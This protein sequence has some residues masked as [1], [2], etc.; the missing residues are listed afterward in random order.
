MTI[1]AGSDILAA[2]LLHIRKLSCVADQDLTIGQPV[3]ISNYVTGLKV[4]KAIK[5]T[6]SATTSFT[7]NSSCE[8]QGTAFA[9]GGDKFIFLTSDTAADT[10]YATVGSIATGTKS[11]SLGTSVAVTTD[12]TTPGYTGCK[13]DTDKFIVFYLEDASTTIVKYRV[14]TVSGTTITFGAAATYFTGGTAITAT[15][16]CCDQL[17]TDKAVAFF[18][19]S[20]VTDS[21]IVA[22]TVSSTTATA[23][24]PKA[25]G[26]TIDNVVDYSMIKKTSTDKFILALDSGSA[27]SNYCQIGTLSGTTITLGTETVFSSNDSFGNNTYSMKIVVPSSDVVVIKHNNTSNISETIVGTISGTTPTFGTPVAGN[28]YDISLYSDT[29]SS[30]LLGNA[31][32]GYVTKYTFSGTT[33]TQVGKC[34]YLVSNNSISNIIS[35][36]NGYF[37]GLTTTGTTIHVYIQGASNNFIGIAQATVSK[38]ASVE[39]ILNGSIDENQSGLIP[40][41]Y[42]LITNGAFETT[43]TSSHGTQNTLEDKYVLALSATQVLV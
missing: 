37:V 40:G 32:D 30:F 34:I 33:I 6:T 11:L 13:L 29:S 24:T 25:I 27:S 2:D 12:E 42:Y 19:C 21:R 31:A 15:S 36:D 18:G 5:L 4:A 43:I 20:T 23:G 9:I 1:A 28:Q 39:V 41:A 22:C 26:T 3:G 14:G 17:A 38:G 8:R 35:M 7:V 16:M 10:L